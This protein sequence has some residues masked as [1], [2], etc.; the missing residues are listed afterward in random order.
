GGQT[1]YSRSRSLS[2]PVEQRG[3]GFVFQSYAIWP[4]MKVWENV[5]YGLRV[6][7]VPRSVALDFEDT[8]RAVRALGGG[9]FVFTAKWE[10]TLLGRAVEYLKPDPVRHVRPGCRW[11]QIHHAGGGPLRGGAAQRGD[12]RPPVRHGVLHGRCQARAPQADPVVRDGAVRGRLRDDRHRPDR[13]RSLRP[14]RARPADRDR[15]PDGRRAR[16]RRR[17]GHGGLDV[18]GDR[19]SCGVGGS[20]GG[21]GRRRHQCADRDGRLPTPARAAPERTAVAAG[22]SL[23]KIVS[24]TAIPF[25]I[26]YR[27]AFRMATAS[28][29]AADHVL[30]KVTTDEGLVGGAEGPARP[31]IYGESQRSIVTAGRDWFAPAITGLDPFEIERV[32]SRLSEVVHNHT[33]KGALD[34]ALH[35][36]QG[37]M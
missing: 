10:P 15:D 22:E 35:D 36:L 4:H 6:R 33:A 8:V 31:M 13:T 26:P 30:V 5:A 34:I 2:V 18:P 17:G 21:T 25:R 37:K 29:P 28:M 32:W 9:R 16:R 24:V 1:L 23:M 11:R 27:S 20:G 3:I 7:K 12:G 14:H 19:P